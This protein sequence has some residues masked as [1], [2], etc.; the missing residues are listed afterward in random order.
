MGQHWSLPAFEQV[1]GACE[2]T[3]LH[4][5]ALP[6]CVSVVQVSE[7]LQLGHVPGGS[8]VSPASIRPLPHPEQSVSVM[9]VQPAGQQLSLFVPHA[10]VPAST[11]WRWHP[12]P[13]SARMVHPWLG[14]DV[15][16]IVP[17]HSS[18]GSSTP[19]PH[20]A[21][22]LLS[23]T[24]LQAVGQHASLL[25]QLVCV[26]DVWHCAWHVPPPASERS[27]QPTCGQV[28]GHDESGSH[29]SPTST[30][31]LPH[32]AGQSTS[33]FEGEVLQ[34]GGQ[35]PSLVVPLHGSCVVEQRAL[36]VF[37]DPVNVFTSQHCPG[38]H[39]V[40]QLAGGSHVSPAVGSII[41]SPQPAQSES[42]CAVHPS[43]QH[44]S[45]PALEHVFCVFWQRT[46]HVAALPVC[47]SVVQSFWS[48]HVGHD[49]GGSHV[50]P[51]SI[52]P[53]P[54]P[55]QSTSV[56]AVQPVGQ[57]VSATVPLH[58]TPTHRPAST[59]PAST[60]ASIGSGATRPYVD[61]WVVF[62]EIVP[63]VVSTTE[64]RRAQ[65][66]PVATARR[67]PAGP[68]GARSARS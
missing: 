21:E 23:L 54:H 28:I 8:H 27:V 48:S 32:W 49:P 18:P 10:M 16:H 53:L 24:A 58:T 11:H 33:R 36:Q 14:H 59:G 9:A 40:G 41:P 30:M 57:H 60:E 51:A 37:G 17:S 2:Q 62:A 13:W 65:L 42:F 43:G 64:V 61:K 45:L 22:Q 34:P 52:R 19:L 20:T 26:P 66:A 3:T 47:E 6:V 46:S 31:P 55:A 39:A 56:S 38:A 44:L 63:A 7:S 4:V 68:K 29:V 25:A 50:S 1:F 15:G 12:V 67:T 35:Q 5:D